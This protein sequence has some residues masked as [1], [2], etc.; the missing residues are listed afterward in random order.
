MVT[1]KKRTMVNILTGLLIVILFIQLYMAANKNSATFD[2]P[3]HIYAGY[4][5]WE[6]DYYTL[7]PPLTRY[8]LTA[9]LLGMNLKEPPMKE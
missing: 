8:M 7:N 9:P 3:A 1:D 5:Q 2:E 6:H 4:L